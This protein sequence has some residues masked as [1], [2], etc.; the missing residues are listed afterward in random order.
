MNCPSCNAPLE[1]GDMFC[2]NCGAKCSAPP[3]APTPEP[4]KKKKMPVKLLA[5]VLAV[6]VLGGVVLA[7]LSRQAANSAVPAV[8]RTGPKPK[9]YT[10]SRLPGVELFENTV[11]VP[12]EVARGVEY[13]SHNNL[14]VH[15]VDGNAGYS[16][17]Q[18]LLLPESEEHPYGFAAK[19]VEINNIGDQVKI[20]YEEAKPDEIASRIRLKKQTCEPD[21]NNIR[22][23]G[24]A[25]MV[26]P[27]SSF[28]KP[29][30]GNL[31][32]NGDSPEV[33]QLAS[34]NGL[35]IS[36]D[37][38]NISVKLKKYDIGALGELNGSLTIVEPSIDIGIG[39]WDVDLWGGKIKKGKVEATLQFDVNLQLDAAKLES[40]YKQLPVNPVNIPIVE[41][42]FPVGWGVYLLGVVGIEVDVSGSLDVTF[43]YVIDEGVKIKDNKCDFLRDSEKKKKP[44]FS[45]FNMDIEVNARAVAE[46]NIMLA[47]FGQTIYDVVPQSG[48]EV[49]VSVRDN[50][51]YAWVPLRILAG[52]DSWGGALGLKYEWEI[53]KEDNSPFKW[54]LKLGEEETTAAPQGN[55]PDTPAVG[56]HVVGTHQGFDVVEFGG[57]KWLMLTQADGKALLLAE[58]IIR[59]R[60][61]DDAGEYDTFW[62]FCSLRAYLNNDFYNCFSE[63]EQQRILLTKNKNPDSAVNGV[64]GGNDTND[65][66]FLLSV[67]EAY[68]CF[69]D[70]H[71]RKAL[72]EGKPAWWWLRSP[73]AYG[74]FAAFVNSNGSIDSGGTP[75]TNSGRTDYG[76]GVR[77]ALWIK[78]SGDLKPAPVQPTSPPT[79]APTNPPPQVYTGAFAIEGKWKS[80]GE[81]GYG[82][83]QPGAIVVFNGIN[84]NFYSPQ[85]TYAFYKNGGNYQ[86]DI[87]SF[88]FGENLSFT[89][90][91]INE[92]RVEVGSYPTI[93]E[94][95]G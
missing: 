86:L 54:T 56:L 40:N 31:D 36:Y 77:P 44:G 89:V 11:I 4:K 68:M 79:A 18:I 39:D 3:P 76:A 57:Y 27:V 5:F 49:K 64:S 22:P 88:L 29:T 55:P 8:A 91:V 59:M 23:L 90:K 78:T 46:L 9:T 16:V 70:D 17:G 37:G 87:T 74:D 42:P 72:F 75:F 32:F 12:E 24:D 62:E 43:T 38:D 60:A 30:I 25:T 83:A 84:C 41:I 20:Q 58:E 85:D 14:T 61:Y 71:S 47:F 66:I 81:R 73:G 51:V 34:D 13:I 95:V 35:T 93:L 26:S 1:P 50:A 19:I 80:V 52:R 10:D 6:L 28:R 92:N 63:S 94:R 48:L 2:P 69:A 67:E 65:K 82:Q 7:A 15:A 33:A 21:L 53:W 45:D